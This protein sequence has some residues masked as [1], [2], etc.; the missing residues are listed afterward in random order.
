MKIALIILKERGFQENDCSRKLK[1]QDSL[2]E[3]ELERQRP[4]EGKN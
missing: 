3:G 2:T 1:F 4:E